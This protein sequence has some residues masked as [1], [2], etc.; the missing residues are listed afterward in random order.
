MF[1][2]MKV[3]YMKFPYLCQYI[4]LVAISY[5]ISVDAKVERAEVAFRFWIREIAR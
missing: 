4:D 5:A 3:L 2:Y 1:A